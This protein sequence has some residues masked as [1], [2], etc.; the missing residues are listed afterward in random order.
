[1]RTT[2]KDLVTAFRTQEILAA[3]RSLLEQGGL[4]GLT[5]EGIAAAAGVA[6]GTLYLYFQSKE[7]LIHELLS[8]V[9]E[10]L[11][12]ALESLIDTPHPPEEKLRQVVTWLLG[13]L[14]RERL[15]FPVFMH[16][17]WRER[18][19]GPGRGSRLQDLDERINAR[20]TSLFAEG[21]AQ[22]RFIPANPRLLSF[23]LRGLVRAVGHYQ[24]A[25]GREVAIKEASPVVLALLFSGLPPKSPVAVEV[26]TP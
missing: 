17:L 8:Q 1:M 4:D 15:L 5:M 6:K 16:E 24:M 19:E 7:E 13:H 20:L 23:L 25:E 26:D 18:S 14:E 9:G 22:G 11:V 3:A 21:I 12:A 10:N 2:K